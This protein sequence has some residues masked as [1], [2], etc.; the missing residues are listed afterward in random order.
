M[1]TLPA[2]LLVLSPELILSIG[3]MVLL[4]FG[5]IR[6]D[7]SLP[8][9]SWATIVLLL[10]AGYAMF[11]YGGN[12]TSA[13][14]GAFRSDEFGRYASALILIG[15]IITLLLSTSFL[16]DQKIARF[17]FPILII[18]CTVGMLIMVAAGSFI[19]LYMGLELQSLAVYVLAAFNRDSLRS[20]EAGLKYFV[21]GALSSGMLLYGISMIYGFTGT[22]GFATVAK[23]IAGS[24]M[25]IGLIFGLVF[26]IAGLA[27]KVSAVPFHMWT[28][29]VYEGAPTPVTAFFSMAPKV[30]AMALVL[31]AVLTAFPDALHQW[32]QVIYALSLLSMV[33]G[34]VAAI[35]QTNI[36]R[37]MAYSSIGHMGYALLG[38]AAGTTA[39]VQGVLI[40]LAIYVPTTA[41]AFGC[42]QAMKRDGE[43]IETIKDLAG[44]SRTRPALAFALMAIMISLSGVPPLA[45]FWAKF[46]VF[47]AAIDA[48]LYVLATVGAVASVVGAYYYWNIF[49][50]MYFDEPVEAFDEDIASPVTGVIAASVVFSLGFVVAGAPLIAVAASAAKALV[51]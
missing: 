10:V 7:R 9:V 21:L 45:G 19:T 20:T 11:A 31:R 24:G 17:E 35:G 1:T 36:K 50:T 13:F 15:S 38:L 16:K 8:I 51:P 40:Y 28:P 18:F 42:I 32:Q 5:V 14:A 3:G 2:D 6:G 25:S 37:L 47:L 49:K 4:V 26:V 39:G 44:L 48:H 43:Q 22:V 46:Y 12:N 41:G 23:V 33:L 29:D 30:A 34:A 27:F